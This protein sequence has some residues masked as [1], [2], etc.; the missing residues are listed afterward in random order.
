[1]GWVGCVRGVG[2]GWDGRQRLHTIETDEIGRMQGWVG[3]V[4]V[5]DQKDGLGIV[6]YGMVRLG[7]LF[8]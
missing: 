8:S 4:F 6:W 3:R 2:F 5:G 7:D 1:M